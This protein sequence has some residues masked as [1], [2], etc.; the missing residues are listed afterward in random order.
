[1]RQFLSF[2]IV[3]FIGFLVDSAALYAAV[4]AGLGLYAGR[5]VSYVIA[6]TSTW[7]LNRSFTFA[8]SSSRNWFAE[9]CRFL[10]SQL[11]GAAVNI[12]TY[13][14]LIFFSPWVARTPIIGVAFGS[15]AGMLVNFLAARSYAF[16]KSP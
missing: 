11:S 8:K 5:M 12:S 3:G 2:G 1:M 9:W 7:I 10:L 16:Q 13:A 4:A 15:I 14:M 6:A